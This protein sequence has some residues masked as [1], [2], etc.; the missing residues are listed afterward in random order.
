MQIKTTVKYYFILT[1]CVCVCVCACVFEHSRAFSCVL[2]FVAWWN[3]A[4]QAP[5]VHGIF[6]ARI[7]SVLAT[8]SCLTLCDPMDCSPLNSSVH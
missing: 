7:R 6:Q 8:Q 3:V 1:L 4:C 5:L 2:L